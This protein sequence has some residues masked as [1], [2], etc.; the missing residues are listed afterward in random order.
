MKYKKNI[1]LLLASVSL[2]SAL[3][4][5]ASES[6]T[7]GGSSKEESAQSSSVEITA[8]TEFELGFEDVILETAGLTWDTVVA[9]AGDMEITAGEILGL[10]LNDLD[11]YDQEIFYGMRAAMPWDEEIEGESF[12]TVTLRQATELAVIYRVA[13]DKAA[14]EGLVMDPDFSTAIREYLDSVRASVGDDDTCFEYLLMQAATTEE[15]FIVMSERLEHLYM[16]YDLYYSAETGT[17]LPTEEEI[18]AVEAESIAQYE[19]MGNYMVKHIL[20][21]TTGEE[22]A[23]A[24]ILAK[25]EEILADLEEFDSEE[26]GDAFH[27]AMLE[28]SEDPGSF[29]YPQG[30]NAYL[31]QMMPE[32]EEA[33]LLLEIGEMSGLV[34]TDYG[35]HIIYRI[36]MEGDGTGR[37]ALIAEKMLALQEAWLAENPI[38]YLPIYEEIDLEIFY[39]NL[40]VLSDQLYTAIDAI[41]SI[42]EES[43]A[44][45]DTSDGE[46]A[47]AEEAEE[48]TEEES[49][50]ETEE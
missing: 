47:T 49:E 36:P 12:A 10:T 50:E 23:D 24:E 35:Y 22:E 34:Q 13:V 41:L 17:D 6:S 43:G 5:C 38:E 15:H 46:D 3:S 20:I 45:E 1:A 31:G 48:E 26:L 2:V 14:E 16:I 44:E 29:T 40:K 42:P 21:S 18:A 30:Y 32:F 8:K 11:T 28:F 9:T 19:A 7:S 27:E 39:T 4:S 33:S 25:A 37:D